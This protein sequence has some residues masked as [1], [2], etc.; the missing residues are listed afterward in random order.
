MGGLSVN[1][2]SLL[3]N[4]IYTQQNMA[5]LQEGNSKMFKKDYSISQWIMII[6]C[7][8]I[9]MALLKLYTGLHQSDEYWY[10][11]YIGRAVIDTVIG[12]S[13][14]VLSFFIKKVSRY[15]DYYAEKFDSCIKTYFRN[16]KHGN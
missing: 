11:R 4:I 1:P 14:F 8:C 9:I 5:S 6:G 3:Y 2:N 12:V 13:F 7:S 15:I 16:D 10:W